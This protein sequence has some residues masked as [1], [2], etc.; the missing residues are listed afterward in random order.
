MLLKSARDGLRWALPSEVLRRPAPSP[1]PPSPAPAQA[2]TAGSTAVQ[3]QHDGASGRYTTVAPAESE[4]V[5]I[6]PPGALLLDAP[7]VVAVVGDA[8]LD[9]VCHVCLRTPAAVGGGRRIL[10]YVNFW[11]VLD[12]VVGW[13]FL[14]ILSY[15][16]QHDTT[17]GA[18]A[19]GRC[20]GAATSASRPRPLRGACTPCSAPACAACGSAGC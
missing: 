8:W 14:W 12:G 3:Q 6:L 10:E 13:I 15:Y 4:A 16:T 19:A 2:V 11:G 17:T 7:A 9:R 18:R 1:P 5:T 20:T